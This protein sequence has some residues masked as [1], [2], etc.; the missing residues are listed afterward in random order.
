[1]RKL[2][3]ATGASVSKQPPAVADS[4]HTWL[5]I[6]SADAKT[7]EAAWAKKK[8]PTG[9]TIHK[10]EALTDSIVKQQLDKAQDVLLTAN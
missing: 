2:A 5:V 10:R 4:H 6:G 8:L 9:F 1:M 7:K 3:E